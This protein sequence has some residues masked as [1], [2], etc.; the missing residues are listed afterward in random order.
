MGKQ[1]D[2]WLDAFILYNISYAHFLVLRQDASERF[3]LREPSFSPHMTSLWYNHYRVVCIY[4]SWCYVR[5][6]DKSAFIQRLCVGRAT[7]CCTGSIMLCHFSGAPEGKII[8]HLFDQLYFQVLLSGPYL[9]HIVNTGFPAMDGKGM[10]AIT[11][12]YLAFNI[13]A[14]KSIKLSSCKQWSCSDFIAVPRDVQLPLKFA[15]WWFCC[16]FLIVLIAYGIFWK[17][18]NPPE[19]IC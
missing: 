19:K 6:S 9:F 1:M 16:C 5:F 15:E 11:K 3:P 4:E 17:Y 8:M 14:I 12:V 10:L 18:R 13:S 2:F 7:S